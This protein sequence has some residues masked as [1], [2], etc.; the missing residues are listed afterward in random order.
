LKTRLRPYLL[1][2]LLALPIAVAAALLQP[3]WNPIDEAA[4]YDLVDQYAH[5]VPASVLTPMRPETVALMRVHGVNPG[6]QLAMPAQTFTSPPPGISQ[7]AGDVW[8]DRHLWQ[9][10]DEALQPPT[11]YLVAVPFW[12]AGEALGGAAGALYAVRLLS[13]FLF[14]LLA[15]ITFG[16]CRLLLPAARRAP[17][18]AALLAAVMPG[19]L[20]T[21]THVANDGLGTVY[22][23]G[24]LL[25]AAWRSARG[26][27]WRSSLL[28]GALLGLALLMKPTAGGIAVAIAVAILIS[29]TARLT[30]RI[31]HAA[32]AMGAGVAVFLPWLIANRLLYGA[33]TQLNEPP[34]LL[35]RHLVPPVPAE[36]LEQVQQL[37]AVSFDFWGQGLFALAMVAITVFAFPGILRLLLERSGGADRAVLAV[38]IAGF[39]G[40]SAFAYVNPILAGSGEPSPGRYLYPALAGALV[41]V[42]AGWW[43]YRLP[44]PGG[45]ALLG[46]VALSLAVSLPGRVIIGGGHPVSWFGH[47]AP[48]AASVDLRGQGTANDLRVQVDAAGYDPTTQA[49]WLHVVATNQS[50]SGSVEWVPNPGLILDGSP[51][52]P[53]LVTYGFTADRL[54]PGD[55]ESGWVDV[56]VDRGRLGAARS[57]TVSFSD[58]ADPGYQHLEDLAVPL[59]GPSS[60]PAGNC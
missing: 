8:L 46:I 7:H 44:A 38:C 52:R 59:C 53:G 36:P 13:A 1:T 51:V 48:T 30:A 14:A 5:G 31:G 60:T 39:A 26:W 2:Y 15:P 43:R 21:G 37:L 33:V 34:G 9:Y 35:I 6:R 32:L 27:S 55:V 54:A 18:L 11:Y 57:V 23:S 49:L 22:G 42:I 41:L 58:V 17:W 10:S 3:I 19:S 50:T 40:Q 29:P 28:A 16:L 45:I 25:Y 24:L 12:L 47:P 4:H 20:Y 56:F